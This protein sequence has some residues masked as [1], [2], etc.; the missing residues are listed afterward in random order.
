MRIFINLKSI[1]V[2]VLSHVR[3]LFWTLFYFYFFWFLFVFRILALNLSVNLCH[4]IFNLFIRILLFP[5][6][7]LKRAIKYLSV[8][9][10]HITI[11]NHSHSIL[12]NW[13]H[14][15][16]V[17]NE[18]LFIF[19]ILIHLPY[20]SYSFS[21]KSCLLLLSLLKRICIFYILQLF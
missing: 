19:L 8:L 20:F 7:I 16:Q 3:F 12:N 6:Y 15:F 11:F 17:Y 14:I 21:D 4:I 13:R 5:L 18:L 10:I 1:L 9:E 2:F